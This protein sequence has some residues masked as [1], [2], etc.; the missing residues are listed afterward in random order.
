MRTDHAAVYARAV[1]EGTLSAPHV[2]V[3]GIDLAPRYV[4]LQCAEFLRMWDDENPKYMVDRKLLAR[5]CRIL[6]VLMMAKGPRT[7]KAVYEA[8]AGYQWLIIAALLCCVHRD[9]PKRRRYERARQDLRRSRPLHPA[10]P[11][12]ASVLALLQRGSRRRSGA[13]DKEGA[14]PAH[15]GQRRGFGWRPRRSARLDTQQAQQDGVQAAELL[16]EPHG[17]Q[18][19]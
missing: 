15:L 6:S 17:R 9:D 4:K 3:E 11:P 18:G 16:D 19:A 12:G 5:I 1:V 13:R 7:G 10:L 2:E 14:R 8:L